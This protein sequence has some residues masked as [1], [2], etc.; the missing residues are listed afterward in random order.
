MLGR[1]ETPG[2]LL[3]IIWLKQLRTLHN[4]NNIV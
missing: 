4:I 2:G 1:V 3:S